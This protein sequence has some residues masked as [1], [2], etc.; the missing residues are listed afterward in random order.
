MS[1]PTVAAHSA[2]AGRAAFPP[3]ARLFVLS[4]VL[5]GVGVAFIR[6]AI[7]FGLFSA[8]A[9]F[10]LLAATLPVAWLTVRL[11]RRVAGPGTTPFE[12]VALVSMPAL[13]LDGL[14]LTWAPAAYGPAGTSLRIPAAW[15]LWFVGVS[16]AVAVSAERRREHAA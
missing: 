10:A 1:Y 16:L 5:W 7:P 15:L 13:L 14:A 8:A 9:S 11:A 12:A 3:L 4:V 6:E 2:T